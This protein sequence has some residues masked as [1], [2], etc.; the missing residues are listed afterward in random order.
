MTKQ[1]NNKIYN[2]NY[3]NNS[4]EE[5]DEEE[6]AYKYAQEKIEQLDNEIKK[7]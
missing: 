6:I 3:D 1:S 4:E 2:N 7:F 5:L